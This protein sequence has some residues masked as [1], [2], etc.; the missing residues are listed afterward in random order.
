M[1]P[2]RR[3]ASSG[4]DNANADCLMQPW[5]H[6]G[7]VSHNQRLLDSFEHWLKEPLIERVGSAQNQAELLFHAPFA[8]ISHGCEAD[9]ILNYANRT[10]LELWGLDWQT[11]IKTPS[12]LTAEAAQRSTREHVLH[13]TS[14]HGYIRGYEGIRIARGELRFRIEETTLWTILDSHNHL[15]G[16]AACFPLWT[17]LGD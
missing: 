8:L 10:A 16:Q 14:R 5:R 2:H 17:M 6:P 7:V 13:E 15:L 4:P 1:V 9:P 12:R 11:L 3:Q